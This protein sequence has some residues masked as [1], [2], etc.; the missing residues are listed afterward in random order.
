MENNTKPN[1]SKDRLLIHENKTTVNNNNSPIQEHL[2]ITNEKE[3]NELI[4]I[5]PPPIEQIIQ[6]LDII[7]TEMEM[8]MNVNQVSDQS[9]LNYSDVNLL[10][11]KYDC[12]KDSIQKP[13]IEVPSVKSNK[14]NNNEFLL[15]NTLEALSP[16]EFRYTLTNCDKRLPFFNTYFLSEDN[17]RLIIHLN[18]INNTDDKIFDLKYIDKQEYELYPLITDLPKNIYPGQSCDHDLIF[19]INI[20]KLLG[21]D[22][23]IYKD[24]I[25]EYKLTLVIRDKIKHDYNEM[26]ILIGFIIE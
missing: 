10:L 17:P 23:V 2:Y 20:N 5:L 21:H 8:A 18:I 16:F 12:L 3:N 1:N 7:H 13:F 25:L 6:P 11:S 22:L 4:I 24:E 15:H 26:T 9:T 19:D 14:T